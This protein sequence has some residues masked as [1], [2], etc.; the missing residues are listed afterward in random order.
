MAGTPI[1][2]IEGVALSTPVAGSLGY[3]VQ[4]SCAHLGAL[5]GVYPTLAAGVSVASANTDWVLGTVTEVVPA[6][7]VTN[8]FHIQGINIESCDRDAVFELVLYQGA[9]DAEVARVRF[10]ILGGFS[11]AI[12]NVTTTVEIPANARIR[13]ALASSNGTALVATVALSVRYAEVLV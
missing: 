11:G 12:V 2:N 10:A 9:G 8:K 6:N 3:L 7:T 4:A 5:L 1:W 13:A